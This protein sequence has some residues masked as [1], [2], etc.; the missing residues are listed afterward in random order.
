VPK[1][2]I[3]KPN[4]EQKGGYLNSPQIGA[5]IWHITS[6]KSG[7]HVLQAT[8][9]IDIYDFPER[10]GNQIKSFMPDLSGL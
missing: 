5:H 6:R 2:G 9:F 3:Y 7:I 10:M 8:I 4:K 1:S